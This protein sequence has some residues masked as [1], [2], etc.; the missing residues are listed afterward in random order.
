MVH[1][2]SRETELEA[3]HLLIHSPVPTAAG[4][5]ME[6]RNL[7]FPSSSP[8]GLGDLTI[9]CCLPEG[10]F[11]KDLSRE[12]EMEKDLL[13]CLLPKW[14]QQLGGPGPKPAARASARVSCVRAC[15]ATSCCSP[16]SVNT[17]LDRTR[18]RLL[19]ETTA[20]LSLVSGTGFAQRAL[21]TFSSSQR[22]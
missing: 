3:S 6:A 2:E 19:R 18:S 9:I 16:R 15:W 14:R 1:L 8:S 21:S 10:T 11:G 22:S 13:A 4:A 5:G 20:W 12:G 17:E 7:E